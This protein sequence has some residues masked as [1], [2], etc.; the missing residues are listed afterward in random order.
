MYFK[1]AK[2]KSRAYLALLERHNRGGFTDGHQNI[3]R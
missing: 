3:Q 1:Q 2:A